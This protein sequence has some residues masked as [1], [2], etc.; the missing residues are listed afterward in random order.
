MFCA[1][2]IAIAFVLALAPCVA[3]AQETPSTQIRRSGPL[4]SGGHSNLATAAAKAACNNAA[5]NNPITGGRVPTRYTL[6]FLDAYTEYNPSTCA[7]IDMGSWA[8]NSQRHCGTP[9]C[10]TVSFGT[11]TGFPLRNG[12][13]PGN[14]YSFAAI[15]YAWNAHIDWQV[16]DQVAA[17]WTSQDFNV[18][19]QYDL[20]V[21]IVYPDSETTKF[22]GW[23]D[24][25]LGQWKQTI[26]SSTDKKFDWSLNSV[27]ETDPGSGSPNN[28]TC[29][30]AGSAIGQFWQITGGRWDVDDKGVWQFDHVGWC[31]A[32][33]TLFCQDPAAP[34]AVEYYRMKQRAPCG[35]TFPQQMQFQAT[36]VGGP[37]QNYG[38]VNT[39][40]GSF[41]DAKVTS[42]RAGQSKSHSLKS[43]SLPQ[44][45]CG[46]T[47]WPAKPLVAGIGTAV[48]DPRPV[49]LAIE[50]IEK[51]TGRAVTYEDPPFANEFHMTP[52]V[53]GAPDNPFLAVP[54]GGTLQFTLP[55]GTSV[56]QE[57]TAVQGAVANYNAS[58]G[59]AT[60]AVEQNALV[61]VVPQQVLDPSGRFV[62]VTPLL[63]TRV[64]L[65]AKP[66]NAMQLIEEVAK[67]VSNTTG[68]TIGMGTMPFMALARQEITTGADN[69]PARNVLE[70]VLA[71]NSMKL[72][73]RLLYD[74]GIKVYYLN[75]PIVQGPAAKP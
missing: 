8:L 59:A 70:K 17:T 3:A 50:Q 26:K 47:H 32:H 65:E 62:P 19:F 42:E 44:L 4:V 15:C 29:W 14:T 12:D 24:S 75:M 73:W 46:A 36:N 66:R 38:N 41:T 54:R 57:V 25:G 22:E 49:A 61:H 30:C 10:G 51:V 11:I 53:T 52:M 33:G 6:A 7:Q 74:P 55:T 21:P 48:T 18:P 69:E 16:T 67:A 23:D 68:Q 35:T 43:P 28:D 27:Q 40:G 56:Q 34:L 20:T 45:A 5:V 2:R 9:N 71:G 60:F 37:W 64:T 63:D 31:S 72:T 1:R 13:C 58:Q 39:L